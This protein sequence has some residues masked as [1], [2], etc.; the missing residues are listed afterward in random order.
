[1]LLIWAGSF[2]SFSQPTHSITDQER[3]YKEAKAFIEKEQ[4]AWAYPM[5]K[6]LKKQYPANTN[7]DHS[8][9]NN[10][11][12]YYYIVCELK[13]MHVIA[14]ENARYYIA[15]NTNEARRQLLSNHLAHYYFLKDDFTT[16]IEYYDLAGYD[17][18]SN[19]QIGDAKFE[20]AYSHFNL[21]QFTLSKPLFNEIHQLTNNKYYIPAN[22]YY[23]FIS[24]YDKNYN[25]AL[26]CFKLVETQ[27]AYKGVVPYYIAEIYYFQ[28]KKE[29]ALRYGESVLARGSSLYYEKQLKLLLGQL[30]FE[31]QDYNKALRLLEDFVTNTPKVTKEVL[32]ELSFCYYKQG[33]FAKA[34]EG[35]KQL[36]NER[37]SMGQNSMYLL[38]DLYLRTNQKLNARNA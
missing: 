31:K 10:D 35:F 8:Y 36:S 37:D 30:Y 6:E 16:A 18:L 19:E 32:Y 22:Y 24:Y 17:N 33:I 12:D 15:N 5:L 1:A 4:Y 14:E 28:G 29:D 21:K 7:S 9:I 2:S 11:I 13:L 25:E 23:G 38:G 20:K 3:S 26:K 27:E 34:I